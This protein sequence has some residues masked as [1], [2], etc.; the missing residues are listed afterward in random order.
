LNKKKIK[1]GYKRKRARRIQGENW[2]KTS[3]SAFKRLKEA[4]E[5]EPPNESSHFEAFQAVWRRA[6]HLTRLGR[7]LAYLPVVAY[8]PE[9]PFPNGVVSFWGRQNGYPGASIV[10]GEVLDEGRLPAAH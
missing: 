6:A 2:R 5:K 4:A 10:V 7:N 9:T 3:H 8:F 1:N